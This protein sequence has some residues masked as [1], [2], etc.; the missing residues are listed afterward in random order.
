MRG[1]KTLLVLAGNPPSQELIKWR[2]D[3]C[4]FSVAVDGGW[5]SF[6][7]AGLLP[8]VL[9]GDGDSF[10]NYEEVSRINPTVQVHKIQD[11]ETTDLEK[12]LQ[13]LE[14]NTQTNEIVILGGL[15]NS[16][17][18]F[19]SNLMTACR[20]NLRWSLTFDDQEEWIRR[21]TSH[22]PLELRGRA[23]SRLSLS[24]LTV[25]EG[26][27][28]EGLQW[29]LNGESLSAMDKFSQS[30]FCANETVKVS[31]VSGVLYAILAKHN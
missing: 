15:G 14:S 22:I 31:L 11:Q 7:N 20:V 27:Y 8:D 10:C 2:F 26:V 29:N 9:I 18:H 3:D 28:T 16:S 13:W 17:D 4:D 23:G 1:E 12:S 24:P 30:N 6:E 5:H 19:L 25:C 21:I